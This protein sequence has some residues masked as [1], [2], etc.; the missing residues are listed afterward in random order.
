MCDAER[1]YCVRSTKGS[2]S[3]SGLPGGK[4]KWEANKILD[5][6]SLLEPGEKVQ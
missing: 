6:R 4:L 1:S 2:N 3:N 5:L